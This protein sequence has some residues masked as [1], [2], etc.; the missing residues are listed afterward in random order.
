M[1]MTMMM[2]MTMHMHMQR[3]GWP[4]SCLHFLAISMALPSLILALAMGTTPS[5]TQEGMM[6]MPVPMPMPMPM[7]AVLTAA[8]SGHPTVQASYHGADQTLFANP[9]RGFYYHTASHSVSMS[10][11]NLNTLQAKR[12]EENITMILR[13]YYLESYASGGSLPS[14]FIEAVDSDMAVLRAAGLKAVLRFAYVGSATGWPPARPYGDAT[15]ATTLAQAAQLGPVLRANADVI[16]LM[17]AGWVG[18]WGEFYYT[19]HFGDPVDGALTAQNQADRRRLVQ[20]LLAALP[21]GR[22]VQLRTPAIK[23][24]AVGMATALPP[25]SAFNGSAAARCGHHN[26][27]FLASSTDSGTYSNAAADKAYLAA[28]TRYVPMGGETCAVN[29]PRSQCPT[30]LA[31]LAMMH[32]SYLNSGYKPEVLASWQTGGCMDEIKRRLGYR[33]ELLSS[34]LEAK[35]RAGSSFTV[36]F[37]FNNTGFAAPFNNRSVILVLRLHSNS[38]SNSS[39]SLPLVRLPL[40]NVDPRRWLPETGL[41]DV[42][43]SLTLPSDVA[44]G[45]YDA[46][47]HL[48]DGAASL[49]ARPEYSIRLSGPRWEPLTGFN[50]L[51]LRVEVYHSAAADVA[52]PPLLALLMAAAMTLMSSRLL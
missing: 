40:P 47:M 50:A 43:T 34:S 20:T 25:E 52:A 23:R 35:V 22:F 33:L 30:A 39:L 12:T 16:A 36:S 18:I 45:H 46:L 49:A 11:L 24:S 42:E 37:T 13:L 51:D 32:W 5:S 6:P 21:P 27:C 8:A 29:A 7:P 41:I 14:S 38:N 44:E 19:D 1:T 26:D 10:A 17:Q 15:V 48:A 3:A 4:A 31:E 2:T 28:E 9:E